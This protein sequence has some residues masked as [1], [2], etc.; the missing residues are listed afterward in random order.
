VL[1]TLGL[2]SNLGER[3]QHLAVACSA[4]RNLPQDRKS[5]V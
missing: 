4:L 5:V 3:E 2:G 1:A